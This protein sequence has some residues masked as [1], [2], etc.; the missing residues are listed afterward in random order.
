MFNGIGFAG[1]MK[2]GKDTS[3]AY[4]KEKIIRWKG[5]NYEVQKMAFAEPLKEIC[6]EFMGLNKYECY[7]QE[8]KAEY[9]EFWGMT[10]REILQR[11]GDG[12]RKTVHPDFWT[13]IMEERIAECVDNGTFF[14]I[15][16]VRYPNEAELIR[17]YG[18]KIVQIQRDAVEPNTGIDHPSERPL[19]QDHVDYVIH[20]NG[21]LHDLE[22]SVCRFIED[23]RRK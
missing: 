12:M 10:N 7:D 18:G 1:R 21:T 15:T 16:D 22:L 17:K 4:A 20:N 11:V 2:S 3:A 13:K 19:S 8:G 6:M 23:Y 5:S 14:I 9:N